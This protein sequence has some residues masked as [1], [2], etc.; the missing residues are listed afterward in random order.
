[1]TPDA[2]SFIKIRIRLDIINHIQDK[3]EIILQYACRLSWWFLVSLFL[4]L[5]SLA[6][7]MHIL[8]RGGQIHSRFDKA[9]VATFVPYL[10]QGKRFWNPLPPPF[11]GQV[12]LL[13]VSPQL[14]SFRATIPFKFP[15]MGRPNIRLQGKVMQ[16]C[17][18]TKN[19]IKVYEWHIFSYFSDFSDKAKL[20]KEH[21]FCYQTKLRGRFKSSIL[22]KI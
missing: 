7:L 12:P 17:S 14:F 5:H 20:C 13:I 2:G 22:L 10:H 15:E 9:F 16:Y 18:T 11:S 4:N 6:K 21:K 19:L 8:Q 1:M 3:I